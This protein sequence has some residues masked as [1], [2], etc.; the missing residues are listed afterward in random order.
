MTREITSKVLPEIDEPATIGPWESASQV[1]R[2]VLHPGHSSVKGHVTYY[3]Q[4]LSNVDF[5]VE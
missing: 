1:A 3:L 4:A 5:T 2:S